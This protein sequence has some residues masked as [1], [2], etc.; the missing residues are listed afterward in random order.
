[1]LLVPILPEVRP[2]ENSR[3]PDRCRICDKFLYKSC[4]SD[5]R[6]MGKA[7]HTEKYHDSCKRIWDKCCNIMAE[8]EEARRQDLERKRA[9]EAAS[10]QVSQLAWELARLDGT[11]LSPERLAQLKQSSPLTSY[12]TPRELWKYFGY[13]ILWSA[14]LE[15]ITECVTRLV[16]NHHLRTIN[17]VGEHGKE[18]I[19]GAVI[20]TPV[21]QLGQRTHERLAKRYHQLVKALYE[22]ITGEVCD[23]ITYARLKILALQIDVASVISSSINHVHQ[24]E[25]G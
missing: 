25:D 14:E 10:P 21:D 23:E 16:D 24:I 11:D 22:E 4:P 9:E 7:N 3:S 20:Q 2:K 15:K 6:W 5:R 8:V 18:W 17:H 13:F 12:F 1:M 19:S